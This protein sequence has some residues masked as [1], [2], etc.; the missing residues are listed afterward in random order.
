M[1]DEFQHPLFDPFP[2]YDLVVC[3]ADAIITN[4]LLFKCCL[5]KTFWFLENLVLRSSKFH[6]SPPCVLFVV[7]L[8]FFGGMSPPLLYRDD[9]R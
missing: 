7:W 3:S 5:Q 9:L 6:L 1:G 4:H 8:I 2:R